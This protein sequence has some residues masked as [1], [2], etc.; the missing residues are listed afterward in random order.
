M[1][2]EDRLN[3]ENLNRKRAKTGRKRVKTDGV[4]KESNPMKT[5]LKYLWEGSKAYATSAIAYSLVG[6]EALLSG[7]AFAL[8]AAIIG[9][10]RKKKLSVLKLL[11]EYTTGTIMG[12]FGSALYSGLGALPGITLTDKVVKAALVVGPGNLAFNALYYS[13]NRIVQND[14][15]LSHLVQDYKTRYWDLNTQTWKYLSIPLAL[16]ANGYLGGYPGMIAVDSAFRVIAEG[17]KKNSRQII[18]NSYA[19]AA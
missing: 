11:K 5:A 16:T 15:N 4:E 12:G 7:G 9:K 8:G 3:N 6:Y 13:V 1:N 10:I 17:K 14:F 2:L 18:P 19:N